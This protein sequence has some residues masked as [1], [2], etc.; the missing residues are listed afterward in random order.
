MLFQSFPKKVVVPQLIKARAMVVS[1]WQVIIRIQGS[2]DDA[3][4]S[5]QT[6]IHTELGTVTDEND[7]PGFHVSRPK[8]RSSSI[9]RK[10]RSVSTSGSRRRGTNRDVTKKVHQK[11]QQPQQDSTPRKDI[12]DFMVK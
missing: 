3:T 8:D 7:P 4:S 11:L 6:P 12:R 9:S 1:E 10:T 5:T 2:L